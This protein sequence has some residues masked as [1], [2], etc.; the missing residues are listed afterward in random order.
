MDQLMI[1]KLA[2]LDPRLQGEHKAVQ[3]IMES[4][5]KL[6]WLCGD[7]PERD[8]LAETPYRVIKAFMEYTEGY[9]ENPE[10]HL[11][12]T[13]MV[14]HSDIVLV[15]DIY[16][17]SM[18][19]HH[20]APFYGVAHVGYIPDAKI[21]GLSKLARLV[22]GY[23]KRFQVQERM[24]NQIADSIE[25][26]LQPRGVM[27]VIQAKHMCM[28]GRGIKKPTSSTITSAVRGVFKN[29]EARREFLELALG[30]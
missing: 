4:L 28:C 21:T 25:K 10:I 12:K 29:A 18:C 30:D 1:E 22:E 13:F 7:D 9:L 16:F 8:G 11:E 14:E 23:A 27:V 6:I 5:Q 26:M 15:K 20:F 24:T 19:E 2:A 3:E 17:N